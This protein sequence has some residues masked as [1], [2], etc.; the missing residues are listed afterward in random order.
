MFAIDMNPPRRQE[1][2][3]GESVRG[4]VMLNWP[5]LDNITEESTLSVRAV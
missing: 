4:A 5:G 1:N 3:P 2:F